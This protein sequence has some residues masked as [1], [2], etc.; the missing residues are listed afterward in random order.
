MSAYRRTTAPPTTAASTWWHRLVARVSA[1][2]VRPIPFL[3]LTLAFASFDIAAGTCLGLAL[4]AKP[5]NLDL[6]AWG[7]GCFAVAVAIL[8][9]IREA[10]RVVDRAEGQ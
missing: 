10:V 3:V 5:I 7:V 6:V 1:S 2:V 8:A 4:D 9:A